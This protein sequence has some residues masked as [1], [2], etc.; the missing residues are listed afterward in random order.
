M[1]SLYIRRV[2]SDRKRRP[3]L[4]WTPRERWIALILA[5]LI[6]LSLVIGGWLAFANRGRR[7]FLDD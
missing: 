5:I 1:A 3:H 6:L 7:I 4:Q 2:R